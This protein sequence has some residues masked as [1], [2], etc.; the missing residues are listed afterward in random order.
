MGCKR[1]L[2]A[3]DYYPALAQANVDVIPAAVTALDGRTVL[4][5]DG[6]RR[7][8]DAI[9]FGTGFRPTD[10][11]LASSIRGRGGV[12]LAERWQGSPRAYMGTTVSGFPNRRRLSARVT[13]WGSLRDL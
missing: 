10:P 7:D 9:I 12:T 6:T 1:V 8:V 4:G 5:E 2:I 3:D 13:S 11:L